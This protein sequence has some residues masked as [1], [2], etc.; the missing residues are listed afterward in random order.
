MFL[1]KLFTSMESSGAGWLDR[2][3]DHGGIVDDLLNV[4]NRQWL[5]RPQQQNL[6]FISLE[7]VA[8]NNSCI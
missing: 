3:R 6:F 4:F 1:N 8:V 7:F 5:I 2:T